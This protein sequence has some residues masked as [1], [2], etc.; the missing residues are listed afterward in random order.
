MSKKEFKTEKLIKSRNIEDPLDYIFTERVSLLFA[1]MFYKMGVSANGV[2]IFSL[3]TGVIGAAFLAFPYGWIWPLCVGIFLIILSAVFDCADGQVARMSGH[4]SLFGRC[5][6]GF[7]DGMVYFAIYVAVSIHIMLWDNIPFT[8]IPWSGWIFFV[9]V[10]VGV[11]FHATQARVA[12]YHKNIYM[13]LTGSK[14]CELSTSKDLEKIFIEMPQDFFHKLVCNSYLSYTKS[15]ERMTPNFQKLHQKIIDN[16]GEVPAKV[17]EMW[18]KG[19]NSTV[20]LS[21][22]LVFNFRTYTLFILMAF[23]QAFWIFPVNII[24]LEA[25]KRFMLI[26]YERLAKRCLEEGFNEI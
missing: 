8:D 9:S 16:G 17:T 11:Y 3:V 5:F 10:P 19:T 4:G 22:L 26:K 18:K 7:A 23:N 24:V 15:Q 14:H 21:N 1:K 12:D 13:Y 20:W 25:L 6:D 2:T